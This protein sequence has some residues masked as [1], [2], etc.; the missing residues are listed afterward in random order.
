MMNE[1]NDA[2]REAAQHVLEL[3]AEVEAAGVAGIDADSVQQA[4]AV[5]HAWIEEMTGIVVSPGLGRVTVLHAEG[6]KSSI[7]SADLAYR[8]SKPV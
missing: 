8:L 6:K 2:I 3:E 7:A 5:L 1:E 4:R